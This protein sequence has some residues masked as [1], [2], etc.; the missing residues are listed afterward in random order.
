MV[1]GE[2][3]DG[4]TWLWMEGDLTSLPQGRSQLALHRPGDTLETINHAPFRVLFVFNH[5]NL[6]EDSLAWSCL[7]YICHHQCEVCVALPVHITN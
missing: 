2:R 4:V 6:I 3:G 5:C 1:W 7:V